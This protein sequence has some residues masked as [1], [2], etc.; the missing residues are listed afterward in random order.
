MPYGP[1][2]GT[3]GLGSMLGGALRGCGQGQQS[4]PLAALAGQPRTTIVVNDTGFS[5]SETTVAPGTLVVF[6][7]QGRQPHSATAWDRFDSGILWPG[8]DCL[9]LFV[10]PGTYEYL[11]IVAADNAQLRGTLTV[12]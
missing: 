9:A 10:T 7:N 6:R 3:M 4:A 5:P 12:R 2:F 11:S 1:A 8:D